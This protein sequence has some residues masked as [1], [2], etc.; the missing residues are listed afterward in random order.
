MNK[1]TKAVESEGSEGCSGSEEETDSEKDQDVKEER[2]TFAKSA[3]TSAPELAEVDEQSKR[4]VTTTCTMQEEDLSQPILL[5]TMVLPIETPAVE[6][7]EVVE[8]SKGNVTATCT[9]QEEDPSRPIPLA[10]I[11]PEQGRRRSQRKRIRC[12]EK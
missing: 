9:M 8:Q 1:D 2:A 11:V 3:T 4:N 12:K 7:A 10:I 6:Q 5:D